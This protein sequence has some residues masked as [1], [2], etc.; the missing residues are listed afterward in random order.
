[1]LLQLCEAILKKFS[2]DFRQTFWGGCEM[3]PLL[4]EEEDYSIDPEGLWHSTTAHFLRHRPHVPLGVLGPHTRWTVPSGS[5][6]R[7]SAGSLGGSRW[8]FTQNCCSFS[9]PVLIHLMFVTIC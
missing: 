5:I 4:Q 1:M 7:D 9:G 6:A 2:V 8:S 3:K